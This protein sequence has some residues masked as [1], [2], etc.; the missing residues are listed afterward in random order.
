MDPKPNLQTTE[1]FEQEF[2]KMIKDSTVPDVDPPEATDPKVQ[3]ASSAEADKRASQE[4]LEEQL[5]YSVQE[6]DEEEE[7]VQTPVKS[8]LNLSVNT[9]ATTL[10]D[11]NQQQLLETPKASMDANNDQK[12]LQLPA[13]PAY[14][15]DKQGNKYNLQYIQDHVLMTSG[16]TG[17][18]YPTPD[19]V[20]ELDRRLRERLQLGQQDGLE[21]GGHNDMTLEEEAYMRS[22]MGTK[23]DM[24]KYET[25]PLQSGPTMQDVYSS[26]EIGPQAKVEDPQRI[27]QIPSEKQ[28]PG[29][30]SIAGSTQSQ[31]IRFQPETSSGANTT[32]QTYYAPPS[33]HARRHLT[34][35]PAFTMGPRIPGR[36]TGGVRHHLTEK[37]ASPNLLS[38]LVTTGPPGKN[39]AP[40][41]TSRP[42]FGPIS[43]PSTTGQPQPSR[44][45]SEKYR[46]RSPLGPPRNNDEPPK[47]KQAQTTQQVKLPPR[48]PMTP[49][50]DQKSG[51]SQAAFSELKEATKKI[52]D[53]KV[54][55]KEKMVFNLTSA[56]K[57]EYALNSADAYIISA[58]V[59]KKLLES[60]QLDNEE[61][62]LLRR[63]VLTDNLR[64]LREM[65][66]GFTF[67]TF[68]SCLLAMEGAQKW[69]YRATTGWCCWRILDIR[70]KVKDSEVTTADMAELV[71]LTKNLC[72]LEQTGASLLPVM[73]EMSKNI[74][75]FKEEVVDTLVVTTNTLDESISQL[76]GVVTDT[77]S[78]LN[79]RTKNLDSH[80]STLM[81]VPVADLGKEHM[82]S[83]QE[84][85]STM[86][87]TSSLYQPVGRQNTQYASHGASARPVFRNNPR[88]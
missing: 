28:I 67:G 32:R 51:K 59:D 15:E 9:P 50:P 49:K 54:K 62:E 68:L 12:L 7:V 46:D 14:C 36:D 33:P 56:E 20:D 47:M 2:D 24:S 21:I 13:S 19:G 3:I 83:Q 80:V 64:G 34:S 71:A 44:G 63:V 86:P 4:L 1:D 5:F 75:T 40:A 82:A 8:Q 61:Y 31:N 16:N 73:E 37:G 77:S 81:K 25:Y 53:T 38:G 23:L 43:G 66:Q 58:K 52:H 26:Q 22:N 48:A 76:R 72:L 39:P 70:T 78:T 30:S 29:G 57:T 35:P 41:N 85:V 69:A 11:W 65:P 6:K 18:S 88:L 74:A 10:S 84:R 42:K 17:L 45:A 87:T 27:A 55:R 60:Q 79:V